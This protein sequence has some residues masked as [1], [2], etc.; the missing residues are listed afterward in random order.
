MLE[1]MC[2][3]KSKKA[4]VEPQRPAVAEV[5]E[6][7]GQHAPDQG[8]PGHGLRL[9][10]RPAAKGRQLRE[11]FRGDRRVFA[12]IVAE[13]ESPDQHPDGADDAEHD[14]G[15][16]PAEGGHQRHHQRW[17]YG[18]AEPGEGMRDA[19]SE[20]AAAGR[21]PV[22][23]RAGG[24]G[25][26]GPLA[27]AQQHAGGE[28]RPEAGDDAHQDCR[29]GPNDAGDGERPAGAEAVGDPA[30]AD[31]QREVGPC[32]GAED[33]PVIGVVEGEFLLDRARRGGDVHPIDI[34]DEIHQTEK[35][36]DHS[37]RACFTN[38]HVRLRQ[39]C[40][41]R[42]SRAAATPPVRA[43][44]PARPRD[45]STPESVPQSVRSLNA[46]RWPMRKTLPFSLPRPWPS[47]RSKRSSATARSFASSWPSGTRTAVSEPDC[48]RGSSQFS[49]RPQA[50][51]A[52]RVAS[53]WR[54]C[55]AKTWA[56]PSSASIASAS[57][58]P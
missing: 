10:L 44:M 6:D 54:A 56:S 41:A 17:G 20:A 42:N 46:P 57:R 9:E 45:I 29:A 25:E 33:E 28:E 52:L 22:G 40:E 21:R 4:Q 2:K 14:E 39:G 18:V 43:G 48:S 34:G 15:T 55:R 37:C 5:H 8:P 11:L 1:V 16:A 35:E 13:V 31:L 50:R 12:R 32:E 47:E 49:S 3:K 24:G 19:L 27:D 53:A 26:G 51:T 30:A 58:R 23:H 38:S 36:E 7:H